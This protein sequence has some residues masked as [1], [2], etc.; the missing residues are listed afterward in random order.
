MEIITASDI[1]VENTKPITVAYI[2]MIGSPDQIPATFTRLYTWINQQGYQAHGPAIAVYHAIPGQV[3]DDQLF[4]ELRSALSGN[5]AECEP[6]EHGLG[7][8]Q[9]GAV[10]VT[11]TRHKGPYE[12]IEETLKLLMNWLSE[13]DYEISGPFEELYYNNPEETSSEEPLTEIRFQVRKK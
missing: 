7:V 10:R 9:I 13:S 4:W 11:A 3:P 6:D 8:K 1:R 12:T 2:S 5:V